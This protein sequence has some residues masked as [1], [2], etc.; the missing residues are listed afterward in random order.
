M[1]DT[2]KCDIKTLRF[3]EHPDEVIDKFNDQMLGLLDYVEFH[4]S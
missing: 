4:F 2:Q 1:P 3:E